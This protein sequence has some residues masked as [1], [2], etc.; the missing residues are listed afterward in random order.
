MPTKFF[1]SNTIS[2][3]HACIY[4]ILKWCGFNNFLNLDKSGLYCSIIATDFATVPVS[5]LSA[6][7]HQSRSNAGLDAETFQDERSGLRR[8]ETAGS[9]HRCARI[10]LFLCDRFTK[11]G[12]SEHPMYYFIGYER[13]R[14]LCMSSRQLLLVIF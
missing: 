6:R 14:I 3:G 5:L 4:A 12:I 13:L 7:R 2:P 10:V 1:T 8:T 9:G 11:F